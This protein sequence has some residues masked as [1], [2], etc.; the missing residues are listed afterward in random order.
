MVVL[1]EIP[2]G[3]VGREHR[4]VTD[5]IPPAGQLIGGAIFHYTGQNPLVDMQP[6]RG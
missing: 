5:E 2:H 1:G 6:Y 3:I 4:R